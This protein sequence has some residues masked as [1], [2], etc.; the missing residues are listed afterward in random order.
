MLGFES[1]LMNLKN[2]VNILLKKLPIYRILGEG[3]NASKPVRVKFPN[4][5][6]KINVLQA[7][8]DPAVGKILVSISPITY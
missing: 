1:K 5:R 6:T 8:R 2:S 4:V 3:G 7:S